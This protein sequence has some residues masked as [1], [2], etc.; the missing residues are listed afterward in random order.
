MPPLPF[1]FLSSLGCWTYGHAPTELESFDDVVISSSPQ[2]EPAGQRLD[3]IAAP[4]ING[5]DVGIMVVDN[6]LAY[7][8]VL[9]DRTR[10]VERFYD[11]DSKQQLQSLKFW[12]TVATVGGAA[13]TGLLFAT[14]PEEGDTTIWVAPAAGVA[15]LSMLGSAALMSRRARPSTEHLGHVELVRNEQTVECGIEPLSGLPLVIDTTTVGRLD[16]EGVWAFQP[17]DLPSSTLLKISD[18]TAFKLRGLQVSYRTAGLGTLASDECLRRSEPALKAAERTYQNAYSRWA[19][20]PLACAD[21]TYSPTC[22]CGSSK[23]GCC[24]HHGGA[25]SCPSP[26]GRESVPRCGL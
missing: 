23:R 4:T 1:I 18:N 11:D 5:A 13:V 25:L 20:R 8:L 16:A 19:R 6:C 24:S 21:G 26:P 2:Q 3:V 12:G 22:T 9:V 10:T 14:Q 7:D 17:Q 15:G